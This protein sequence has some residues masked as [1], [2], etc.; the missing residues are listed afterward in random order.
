MRKL[1]VWV[2]EEVY[3]KVK[4]RDK[5]INRYLLELILKDLSITNKEDEKNND[6][7]ES[8]GLRDTEEAS[9]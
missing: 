8:K 1:Q 9:G 5:P 2:S 7:T 4:L 6:L 3:E